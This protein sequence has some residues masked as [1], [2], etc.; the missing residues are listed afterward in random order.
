MEFVPGF[1]SCVGAH[2]QHEID[3]GESATTL[4]EASCMALVPKTPQPKDF[5]K[6]KAR[7][8]TSHRMKTL[9]RLVLAHLRL[10]VRE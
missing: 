6:Y 5:N 3:V 10:L 4:W 8:V 1:S 2:L 9:E 7:G